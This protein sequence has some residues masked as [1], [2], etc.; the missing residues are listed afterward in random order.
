LKSELQVNRKEFCHALRGLIRAGESAH[1]S[2]TY[3]DSILTLETS[4]GKVTMSAIGS[5]ETTVRV[6]KI[7][8]VTQAVT[9]L[10]ELPEQIETIFIRREKTALLL[11]RHAVSCTTRL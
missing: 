9:A 10:L 1:P 4:N 8:E 11:G 5:W 6:K 2:F 7:R 3:S